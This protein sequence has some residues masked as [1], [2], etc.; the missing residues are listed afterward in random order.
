[1]KYTRKAIMLP[2]SMKENKS[3]V[4]Y[5]TDGWTRK[6]VD[7]V[8]ADECGVCVDLLTRHPLQLTQQAPIPSQQDS[9]HLAKFVYRK[10]AGTY[11]SY[12]IS[13]KVN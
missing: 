13:E 4:F 9:A 5:S 8:P 7:G 3:I 6:G 12:H 1:M 2:I 10:K 11:F